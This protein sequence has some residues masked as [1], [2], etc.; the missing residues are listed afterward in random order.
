MLYIP[1]FLAPHAAV[2]LALTQATASP[3]V[4]FFIGFGSHFLL[5]LIPH[6]DAVT[7][8]WINA[9]S[10]RTRTLLLVAIADGFCSLLIFSSFML[11]VA[12]LDL[13]IALSAAFGS[14]LPDI[15]WGLHEFF[16]RWT[17]FL[18]RYQHAHHAWGKLFGAD[19]LS[20]PAGFAVQIVTVILAYLTLAI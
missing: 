3:G 12:H 18:A 16:P 6:A 13:A 19:E 20:F 7:T 15:L 8:R 5:D 1:M 17:S 10:P 4:A 14:A 11:T 2:A 9:R